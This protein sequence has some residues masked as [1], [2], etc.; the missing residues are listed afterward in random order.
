MSYVAKFS[1]WQ[2]NFSGTWKLYTS[3]IGEFRKN[4]E[5]NEINSEQKV[6]YPKYSQILI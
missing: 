2:M 1:R 3:D 5:I 4:S 6:K